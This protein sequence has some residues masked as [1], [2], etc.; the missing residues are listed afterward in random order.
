MLSGSDISPLSGQRDSRQ[1]ISHL[2]LGH[3]RRIGRPLFM[4]LLSNV[5]CNLIARQIIETMEQGRGMETEERERS[6]AGLRRRNVRAHLQYISVNI[7]G[8]K[9]FCL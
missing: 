6:A 5:P 7:E 3:H 1:L 4:S 9:V 2:M 8:T